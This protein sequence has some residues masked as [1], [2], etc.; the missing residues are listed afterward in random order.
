MYMEIKQLKYFVEVARR[1]HISEAKT[2]V[3]H[4]PICNKSANYIIRTRIA[5]NVIQ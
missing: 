3:E 1:E 2:W 4:S 5:S